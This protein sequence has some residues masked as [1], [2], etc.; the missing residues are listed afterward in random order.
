VCVCVCVGVCVCVWVY[1]C[2]CAPGVHGRELM[3]VVQTI[4]HT[5]LPHIQEPPGGNEYFICQWSLSPSIIY[6]SQ[7]GREYT[8]KACLLDILGWLIVLMEGEVW[9]RCSCRDTHG[10][11]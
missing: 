1:V 11:Q 6:E 4:W 10:S 3:W 5:A 8:C 2:V 7:K 9:L